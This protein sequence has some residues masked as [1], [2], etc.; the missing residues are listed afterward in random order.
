[1]RDKKNTAASLPM[2]Q[3][4]APVVHNHPQ[5]Y[6]GLAFAI[7]VCVCLGLA[8]GYFGIVA[9]AAD[10][11]SRNPRRDVAQAFLWI[12]CGGGGLYCASVV[13]SKLYVNISATNHAHKL[14]IMRAMNE[15]NERV[16]QIEAG[17]SGAPANSSRAIYPDAKKA[18]AAQHA[19]RAAY[20]FL[21]EK[22]RLYKGNEKRPWGRNAVLGYKIDGLKHTE[23]D[24]VKGWLQENG[25]I[26]T[27]DNL[28]LYRYPHVGDAI[29]A[30]NSYIAPPIVFNGKHSPTPYQEVTS[31]I[32]GSV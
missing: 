15:H 29:R 16:A 26:T 24:N 9:L 7:F 19:I 22:D 8:L 32:D 30:L 3:P 10:A 17:A 31:V 21:K 4:V 1:M 5:G 27:D 23:A 18:E 28:N 14:E 11:G 20:Q 2:Q 25:F 13:G 12:V 6:A